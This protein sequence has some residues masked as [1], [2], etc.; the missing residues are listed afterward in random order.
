MKKILKFTLI[1]IISVF[2]IFRIGKYT[3]VLESFIIE[4]ETNEP[5]LKKGTFVFGTNLI[6]PEKFGYV[7][8]NQENKDFE[9]GLWIHRLCGEENDTIEIINGTLFVNNKNIDENL[10]LKRFY[11]ISKQELRILKT[12][13]N[14]ENYRYGEVNSDS[15]VIM[16]PENIAEKTF[17][18]KRIIDKDPN[19]RIVKAYEK[20]WSVDN[21][22][23]LIIPKNY[24]FV[25]ADN[26]NDSFD[27][28]FIGLIEK[29][30][31]KGTLIFK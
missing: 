1:T 22:G 27:S 15:I 29:K 7:V 8:Y 26:R 23:P 31:I 28:R 9:T 10:N 4:S 17:N 25:L 16:L 30:N 19:K 24:I 12:K 21:F 5:N 2:V 13:V 14:I 11:K 6:S 20:P 3:G 18:F